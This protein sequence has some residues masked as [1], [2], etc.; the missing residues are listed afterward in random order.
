MAVEKTHLLVE[1]PQAPSD[2]MFGL[3]AAYRA[4]DSPEKA[5][6]GVGAYR[7][8]DGKPFVLPAV[9]KVCL[10]LRRVTGDRL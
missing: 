10:L 9:G 1:V 8:G 6:L 3:S 7:G 2:V 5:D 4:D